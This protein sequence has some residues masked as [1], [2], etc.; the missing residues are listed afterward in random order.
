MIR[1]HVADQLQ[2]QIGPLRAEN[3]ALKADNAELRGRIKRLE[4]LHDKSV[5]RLPIKGAA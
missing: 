5:T 4:A 3:V 1:Q 2:Q